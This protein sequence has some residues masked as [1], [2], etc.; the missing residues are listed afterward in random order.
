ML[1][2]KEASGPA[3]ARGHL[4]G[5][6]QAVVLSAQRRHP[7]KPCIVDHARPRGELHGLDQDRGRAVPGEGLVERPQRFSQVTVPFDRRRDA[8]RVEPSKPPT[9]ATGSA[10]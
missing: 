3:H 8:H 10:G 4:I 6:Q 1:R 5:D 2:R 9:T 7:A